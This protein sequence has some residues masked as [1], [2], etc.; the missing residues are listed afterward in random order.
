[1][2]CIFLH[3]IYTKALNPDL[4]RAKQFILL[5][6]STYTFGFFKRK[7]IFLIS[8]FLIRFIIIS[9]PIFF[10]LNLNLFSTFLSKDCAK[11]ETALYSQILINLILETKVESKITKIKVC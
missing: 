10:I 5:L 9:Y 7:S 4:E 6:S 1:M 8:I 2:K 11:C 3:Y